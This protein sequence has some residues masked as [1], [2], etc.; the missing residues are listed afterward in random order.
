MPRTVRQRFLFGIMVIV[1]GF[2]FFVAHTEIGVTKGNTPNQVRMTVD[3]T[4]L[5][6]VLPDGNEAPTNSTATQALQPTTPE[7]T[8]KTQPQAK[9]KAKA[10][11]TAKAAAKKSAP[12]PA[13][14]AQAAPQAKRGTQIV[15]SVT[16]ATADTGTTLTIAA[17]GPVGDTSYINLSN[18][19]RLVLDLREPWVSKAKNVIRTANGPIKYIVIGEHPD[20]LRMVVHFRTLPTQQ[21]TPEF[22]RTGK[23]LKIFIPAQ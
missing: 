7:Q 15:K 4:V 20:R 17:N 3:S 8:P 5:P 9:P 21:I 18:P 10:T 14:K 19:R 23:T 11:P 13:P 22:T 2:I 1:A 6:V 12:A 16:L